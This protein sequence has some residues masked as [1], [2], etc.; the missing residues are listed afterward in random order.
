MRTSV[1]AM[2]LAMSVAAAQ[3]GTDSSPK[4]L[5]R[6][7]H[8]NTLTSHSNPALTI[9]FSEEYKYVGGQRWDLYG[10]ADAEQHLFVKPGPDK[11][12]KSLYWVQFESFLPNNQ[13]RYN[14]PPDHTTKIGDM[15]FIYD[16]RVYGDYSSLNRKPSSDGAYAQ[17]LLENH[18]YRFLKAAIRTRMIY[19]PTPDKRSELMIIYAESASPHDP[20]ATEGMPLDDQAPELAH[21]TLKKALSGMQIRRR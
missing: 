7:V 6:Q 11:T 19:L 8:G 20:G 12:I 21:G 14:Y 17:A 16:T 5:E 1:L 18:G 3:T 9:T 10:L 4:P 15:E 13:H 2:C